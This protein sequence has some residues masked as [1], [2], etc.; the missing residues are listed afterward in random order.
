VQRAL[1]GAVGWL[2][3]DG[4]SLSVRLAARQWWRTGVNVTETRSLRARWNVT[5]QPVVT[6]ARQRHQWRR[7]PP[8]ASVSL[9]IYARRRHATTP[10]QARCHVLRLTV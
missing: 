3:V 1:S 10:S 2:E 9:V 5:A 6:A 4:E 7:R 8:A